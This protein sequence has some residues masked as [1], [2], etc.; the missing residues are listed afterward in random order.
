MA[1]IQE[2]L[3]MKR[4]PLDKWSVR[5]Q[6]CLSSAVARSGDQNWMSV[7]RALK[8][9]G[10]SN[11][12]SDWFHQKN[13]AAQ[14]GALLENVETPKRKKRVSGQEVGIETP[15]ES[16]LRKLT[17][18][19]K[20]E[21]KKLMVEERAEFLKLQEDM[22]M[23]QSGKISEEQLEQWC[24]EIDEEEKQKEQEALTHAAWL[25]EREVRKQEIE[26]QWRP[27]INMKVSPM[28]VGQK[29]KA[30]ESID[31]ASYDNTEDGSQSSQESSHQSQP[32][33]TPTKPPISPLLTSLLKSPSHAQNIVTSSILHSA[34]TSQRGANSISNPT[35]TSLLNSQTNVTVSPG[36]QQLVS[37][38]IGQE[39]TSQNQTQ[40][41]QATSN[42]FHNVA[43]IIGD[44]LFLNLKAE[45]IGLATDDPLPEIKNE[46][47]EVIISDLIENAE[48]VTNPEQHLQ[49]DENGDIISNFENELDELVNEENAAKE[50]AAKAV[51][52]ARLETQAQQEKE[53]QEQIRKEQLLK[54]E[55]IK[56]EQL[57]QEQLRFEKEKNEQMKKKEETSGFFKGANT[58]ETRSATS[59]SKAA[60]ET[61]SAIETRSSVSENRKTMETRFSVDPKAAPH[62]TK[63]NTESTK[64]M[65]RTSMEV[66]SAL[67]AKLARNS[68]EARKSEQ[69]A[70]AIKA[71]P[72][73]K[74]TDPF[75]FEEDPVIFQTKPSASLIKS[76]DLQ[77]EQSN[78]ETCDLKLN[79]SRQQE[80]KESESK[81]IN[82]RQTQESRQIESRLQNQTNFR[83]NDSNSK[84]DVTRQSESKQQEQM[85]LLEEKDI[86]KEVIEDSKKLT[87]SAVP[88]SVE[89]VEVVVLEDEDLDKEL[90]KSQIQNIVHTLNVDV[91]EESITD[92][93]EL[94][95][96]QVECDVKREFDEKFDKDS[97]SVFDD[98]VD[99][100][101]LEVKHIE[102][103]KEKAE[104]DESSDRPTFTPEYGD[105][106]FDDLN[107]AVTK[108]DKSGKAK[109]DYSRKNKKEEKELDLILA[110]EQAD[111][112][113]LEE[114]TDTYSEKDFSDEKKHDA[115]SKI[116][117][118]TE[119]SNSPWTEEEENTVSSRSRRRY[120]TP[121]TPI[122]S[123]PNSPA[124]GMA[125][126]DDRE[127]RNW[128]K[129]VMLV[130]SRLATH[131]Y[132]SLFLKPIT[133][134]Q[135]P[136]YHNTVYRPMDLQTI[137][138]NIE[139]GAIRTTAE[140]QRDVLLMFN[141]AI[142]YNK[143]NDHVY[144]MAKQMQQE[145]L[146]QIQI[147]L[148]VGSDA[149]PRRETRTSEPGNK[150]KRGGEEGRN[151]KRKED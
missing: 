131:K 58:V 67:E 68:L 91:K 56:Q 66:R 98:Q 150:R 76:H 24:K 59:D 27:L 87:N 14:Y 97:N 21:L 31:A 90:N 51:E 107:I 8:P 40:Q 47:V 25:K 50:E 126:E 85:T 6:L 53:R 132:A 29:R 92:S 63:A 77:K 12:P 16:I 86:K 74:K 57:R 10:D 75:E 88:G 146:Q 65:T 64:P 2:R 144:N 99:S 70:A 54:Q 11:R 69:T 115:K 18:E 55:Q 35:I 116:K 105:D 122:D 108:I 147:L 138:K 20:V 119:R 96:L 62:G 109:R 123:I 120:S 94:E 93:E 130:Y 100:I 17:A 28:T 71:K 60:V 127:Y 80:H 83:K 9:F 95:E 19:R 81:P 13:C 61:R 140:F 34:I 134:D 111:S 41:E 135:A 45:D 78:P 3:Q 26:R 4:E 72:E 149:P 79:E 23:L 102:E 139:T 137:R 129:S 46:E 151:K 36:L 39:P 84:T 142:M 110:A 22:A 15:A 145:S 7:S 5:E 148:Q 114:L 49:L 82:T 43:D 73:P 37:S 125:S 117:N 113:D 104:T 30:S 136:G 121:A 32:P 52:R 141:N 106:I 103:K 128:K 118:D 112:A 89:I 38:A 143:T 133:N 42:I 33:Q 44:P 124:S 1:S 101:D 48:I